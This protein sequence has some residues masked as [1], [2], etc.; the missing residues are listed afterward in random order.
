M[1]HIV[2]YAEFIKNYNLSKLD[3]DGQFICFQKVLSKEQNIKD[4]SENKNKSITNC[5]TTYYSMKMKYGS[6]VKLEVSKYLN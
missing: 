1:D 6:S 5:M 2:E 3:I 4:L